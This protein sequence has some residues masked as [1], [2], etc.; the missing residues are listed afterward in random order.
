[1]PFYGVLWA[2]IAATVAG[3]YAPAITADDDGI[4]LQIPTG[5]S[6]RLR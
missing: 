1:M 5:Q 6:A 2:A 3:Q 4:T